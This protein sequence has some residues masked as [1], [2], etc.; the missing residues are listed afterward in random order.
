M[1]KKILIADDE[2]RIAEILQAY[3]EREGFRV[4][5]TYDGK[6]ALAKFHEENPDLII[7]D[8]MLPEISGW[9]VCREIRKES[10]VPIIML[11]ARDELTDKLIGLEIGADDYMTKPFESKELVARVKVQ[12]RRSEYP[13]SPDSALVID[14]L[15]I[16]QERRLV[17]IDGKTVDL[18]ATEF[19]ILIS[20][21]VSPGRVFSRMQILDKLGEAYEGYERTIDSHIKNL[22][23][24]IEPNLESPTYILTVHGVGYKMKDR[25]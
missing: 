20:L 7:L 23:K 9:D 12:L 3:L 8:L 2:K 5:A 11:T 24:K 17:K 4:I 14:Q 1:S 15:E 10:H 25:G 22:R 16:D 13:P 6:T 21:A 18:T 19:D